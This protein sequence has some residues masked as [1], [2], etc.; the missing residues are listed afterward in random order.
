MN[1]KHGTI[2][3]GF[4]LQHRVAGEQRVNVPRHVSLERV[5]A[6]AT[7]IVLDRFSHVRAPVNAGM[8]GCG[9]RAWPTVAGVRPV[10]ER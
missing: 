1:V 7:S 10:P 3:F 4:R 8:R 6:L 2:A 9:L 5:T